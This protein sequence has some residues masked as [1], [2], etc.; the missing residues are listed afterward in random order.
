MPGRWALRLWLFVL[1]LGLPVTAVAQADDLFTISGVPVDVTAESAAVAREQ[2]IANG[3]NE[4]FQRLLRRLSR[5]VDWP[6]LPKPST[7]EL[8]GMLASFR[9]L[10]EKTAPDRYIAKLAFTFQKEPVQRLLQERNI[11]YTV[12]RALP[13]LVLPVL[14]A[15]GEPSLWDEPNPWLEAWTRYDPTGRL[16]P[17]VVPF[18]DI[19][20]VLAIT[21]EQAVRGD[22]EAITRA[23]RRYRIETVMVADATLVI[24]AEAKTAKLDV[25]LTGHGPDPSPTVVQSF[26][27]T[28]DGGVAE[29]LDR[30]VQRM[31]VEIDDIWKQRTLDSFGEEQR[32]TALVPVR[33]LADWREIQTRIAA[34]P[35]VRRT[36]LSALT[37]NDAM[38]VLH[39]VGGADLLRRAMAQENLALSE[40]NGYWRLT[41][42]G[43]EAQ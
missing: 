42:T 36:E 31:V 41:R 9:V 24:D 26:Q 33:D 13:V 5:Q 27:G 10:E 22:R 21:A 34:V 39:H 1:A 18:G 35:M 32:L 29:L 19:E 4:A 20:D 28:A 43:S 14:R 16:V 40:E 2:A 11:P 6:R 23:A 3:R 7:A 12:T 17:I 30:A 37:V 38:V 25:A 8:Q 15:G